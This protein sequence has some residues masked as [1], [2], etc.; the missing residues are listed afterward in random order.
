MRKP[1][2][3]ALL[4]ADDPLGETFLRLLSERDTEVGEVYPLSLSDSDGCATVRGE[5]LP[6]QEASGF[7]WTGA[8]ILVNASRAAAARRFEADAAAAGCRVIAFARAGTGDGAALDDALVVALHR[9]LAPIRLDTALAAVSVVAML[10]VAAAG[11]AGIAE[12]AAQTRALFA[13]ETPEPEVFPLQIAFNLIPQVDAIDQDGGSA[14]ERETAVRLG[15]LLGTPDL[16]VSV[17][18]VWAPL[19]YG[20]ALAVHATTQS[21]VDVEAVRARLAGHA[22]LTLMDSA[23]PGGVA[24]PATDAQDSDM[25]FVSR[26][27]P[28]DQAGMSLDMW[29]VFDLTRLEATLLVDRLENLIE[30]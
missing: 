6:L 13:M 19:F 3:I 14:A 17:T 7:D 11:E 15:R 23:L 28:G 20:A 16:P 26:L 30:K 21:A 8:G 25:V 24:T 10:P 18:A 9:V 4:G 5:E 2:N 27:R 12:L 29:L 1:A 22:G